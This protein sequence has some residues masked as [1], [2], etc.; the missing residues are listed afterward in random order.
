[1]N[2]EEVAR[3]HLE[4]QSSLDIDQMTAYFSADATFMPA[5]GYPR[6]RAS[7]KSVMASKASSG[8]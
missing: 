1:M 4:A 8:S 5:I 2:P 7:K 6:G 3:A